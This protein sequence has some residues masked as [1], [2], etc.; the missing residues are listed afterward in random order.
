MGPLVVLIG[1]LYLRSGLARATDKVQS[2]SRWRW[3]RLVPLFV[4]GFI[5]MAALNS[6]HVFPKELAAAFSDAAR[7][8][9]LVA[10][11]G[12]GLNTDVTQLRAVGWRPLQV[13]FLAA[14]CLSL[15]ALGLGAL[16]LGTA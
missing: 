11:V 3:A 13:G 15:F 7:A 10:L 1:L 14:A 16:I 4:I 5:A 8:L 2:A 6:W 9:I 12:V